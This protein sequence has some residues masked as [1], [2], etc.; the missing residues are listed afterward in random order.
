M[1]ITYHPDVSVISHIRDLAEQTDHV[2]VI[3]NTANA[4]ARDFLEHALAKTHPETYSLVF[5]PTN[6]GVA[7]ALN[8]GMKE[9]MAHQADWV[10]T[11]DQDSHITSG[12]VQTMLTTFELLAPEIKLQT[13]LLAPDI[14]S[15]ETIPATT[16]S[17][18]PKRPLPVLELQTAITSGTMI[19]PSAWEN[20]GG[21]E[22]QLFIDYVDHDFCFRLR[23]AGWKI[24][25]CSDAHLVHMIGHATTLRRW[26]RDIII[27]Q[28]PPF[29]SYYIIRNGLY[30]WKKN[31]EPSDFI[32]ADKKNTLKLIIKAFLFDTH[33]VAR[34]Y[35]FWQGY[36]DFV[37]GRFGPYSETHPAAKS[38]SNALTP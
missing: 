11:M 35:M 38:D 27:D 37:C 36:K 8:R 16:R 23:K 4:A 2:I 13:A 18:G 29:R 9:A 26:G 7:A 20:V 19:K 14:I 1:I 3:D 32:R 33:K 21:F 31:N 30:F 28:H 15:S 24:L 22:E 34:I 5:N 6:A 25:G 17:H 10:L 12:T